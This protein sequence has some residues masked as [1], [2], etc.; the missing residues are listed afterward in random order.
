MPL[1]YLTTVVIAAI[2]TAVAVAPPQP[3]RS[4]RRSVPYILGLVPI[5]APMVVLAL[6]MIATVVAGTQ[7]DLATPVGATAAALSALTAGGLVVLAH[8]QL[9]SASQVRTAFRRH[10]GSVAGAAPEL[11]RRTMWLGILFPLPVRPRAV[12]RIAGLPYGPDR[13]QRLDVLH[14]PG[15]RAAPILVHFHGGFRGGGRYREARALLHI[16]AAHGWV[17]VSAD[18][19]REP[20]A[21]LD[22]MRNDARAVVGWIREHADS[23]GAD[24]SHVVLVGSSAGAYLAASAAAAADPAVAAVV[25]WY[26]FYGAPDDG[27][28]PLADLADTSDLPPILAVHG[29]RDTVVLADD[30]RTAVAQLRRT[31]VGA[32]FVGLPHAQHGF[33]LLRSTRALAVVRITEIFGARPT[34]LRRSR[35]IPT[36]QRPIGPSG[37][38]GPIT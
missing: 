37:P 17:T 13:D 29:E 23:F 35:D 12:A 1:G 30:A 9:R 36:T 8:R 19:R 5:E 34:A 2:C 28:P 14:R 7:G 4:H 3:A 27:V 32:H 31:G 24:P 25:L 33:D 22:E 10:V 18:H 11:S 6:L 15:S 21:D 38:Y 20:D 26:G 16:L